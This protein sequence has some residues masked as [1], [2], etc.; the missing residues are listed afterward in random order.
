MKKIC[1][2]C[3]AHFSPDKIDVSEDTCIC[4]YCNGTFYL[5]DLW[6]Q[7]DIKKIEKML[8]DPPKGTWVKKKHD[9]L[10][11]GIS[12]WWINIQSILLFIFVLILS[13]FTMLTW[14]GIELYG[15]RILEACFVFIGVI[16]STKVFLRTID[17]IYIKRE[18]VFKKNDKVYIHTGIGKRKYIV[19]DSIKRIY[20]AK[21]ITHENIPKE[22][23]LDIS[24][25]IFI[26][27]QTLIK[28]PIND[29]N[30]IKSDFLLQAL[31]YYRYKKVV[32]IIN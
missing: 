32:D 30:K 25:D 5:S 2:K 10:N 29:V 26:E 24:N 17:A 6:D 4:P 14:L 11:I 7:E 3:K 23:P 20:T 12:T 22:I 1:P 18:I 13:P 27:G 28:I 8:L 16:V 21:S 31:K 19:W 15:H 9:Q